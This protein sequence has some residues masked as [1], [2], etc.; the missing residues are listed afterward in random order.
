MDNTNFYD[1]SRSKRETKG[2]LYWKTA[3]VVQRRAQNWKLEN[4]AGTQDPNA[5]LRAK[6][7]SQ[8]YPFFFFFTEHEFFVTHS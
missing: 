4:K 3:G 8:T 1:P 7:R 2:V 6:V 5:Y